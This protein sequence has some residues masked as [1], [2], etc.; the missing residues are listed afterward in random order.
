GGNRRHPT[1]PHE[2]P[3]KRTGRARDGTRNLRVVPPYSSLSLRASRLTASSITADC[4]IFSSSAKR[5]IRSRVSGERRK[6]VDSLPPGRGF[7]PVS[8]L[9]M[10]LLYRDR[11]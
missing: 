3:Q 4:A 7:C 6:L 11:R 5:R 2:T 9:G 1:I 8:G 10:S